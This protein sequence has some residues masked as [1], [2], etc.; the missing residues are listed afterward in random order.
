MDDGLLD[1]VIYSH[2]SKLE[3]LRHAISISQGRRSF[4]R[5][6][7]FRRARSLRITAD[8]PL[9]IQADG[10]PQGYTPAIVKILPGALRVR[11]PGTEAPGLQREQDVVE[12]STS[13]AFGALNT[14]GG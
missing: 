7:R 13:H 10:V 8:H 6:I 3:Y 11:V 9:E 1:V 14:K 2:F 4:Q 5:N 12:S